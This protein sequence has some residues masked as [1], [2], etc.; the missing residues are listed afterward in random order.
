M[1]GLLLPCGKSEL[2]LRGI[3]IAVW[4][5]KIARLNLFELRVTAI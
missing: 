3:V 2:P 5:D 4:V 1:S